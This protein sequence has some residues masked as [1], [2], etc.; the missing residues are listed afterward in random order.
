MPKRNFKHLSELSRSQAYKRLRAVR[1]ANERS[2]E[3]SNENS[4]DSSSEGEPDAHMQELIIPA[5]HHVSDSSEPDEANVVID[6]AANAPANNINEELVVGVNESADENIYSEGGA[7]VVVDNLEGDSSTSSDKENLH[8]RT[9]IAKFV[10]K[11]VLSRNA[12]QDLL[13]VLRRH[14]CHL[15]LPRTRGALVQT[16]R[17]RVVLRDVPPGKYYHFGLRKGL[18]NSLK[19]THE[20]LALKEIIK[21][22]F[23]IDGVSISKSCSSQ[24]VSI[25][26]KINNIQAVPV[27]KV[28]VYHGYSK[29]DSAALFLQDF[30]EESY[31]LC[32]N[33]LFYN[34]KH[35]IVRINCF[36]CDLPAKAFI[37]QVRGHNFTKG[38]GKCQV[39]GFSNNRRMCFLDNNAEE[40]T[41]E[42]IRQKH[43]DQY[44]I[45]DCPL[46]R[47]PFLDLVKMFPIDPLHQLYIGACKKIL[48]M[49]FGNKP[50]PHRLHRRFITRATMECGRIKRYIPMEFQRKPRE[51]ESVGSFKATEC[52]FFLLYTG[53]VIL[54][55]ILDGSRKNKDIYDHFVGLHVASQMLSRE[56]TA[57]D[58][59][60]CDMLYRNFTNDFPAVY[61]A[62]FVSQNIHSLIHLAGDAETYGRLEN[63]S[64]FQYENENGAIRKLLKESPRP[65]QQLVKRHQELLLNFPPVKKRPFNKVKFVKLHK[66]G[67]LVE[68]VTGSQF[69]EAQ[70]EG[71]K[72]TIREPDNC[73]T[74]N[75]GDVCLAM[76]FVKNL[77]TG[78]KVIISMI[79]S[80]KI[81]L[82]TYPRRSS[83]LGIHIVQD[84]SNRIVVPIIA[85]K[86]KCVR[87]PYDDATLA[88][89]PMA[90]CN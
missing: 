10:V 84:C 43:D 77:L 20:D 67:S 23:N 35:F 12:T 40:R 9:E 1:N 32:T 2:S 45:S 54:K 68:G 72:L 16:P 76:N 50:S 62:E 37:L 18:V 27:F 60:Y 55:C 81:D 19:L 29:P 26:G 41:D 53:P 22:T 83:S 34:N 80:N 11:N 24:F 7:N 57:A 33:G 89:F 88:V 52:R 71:F 47:I 15:S 66:N 31:D 28:G 13:R 65:L 25:L 73:F 6:N 4:E 46:I 75:T 44:N 90:H 58:L 48:K 21:V 64:A 17:E 79:Y 36:V 51:V 3:S 14:D 39:V 69:Q 78:D 74:T 63:F 61:A 56:A 86:C 49:L 85:V 87:V 5:A 70:F 82:Y 8:F 30:V 38:C 42:S 59:A